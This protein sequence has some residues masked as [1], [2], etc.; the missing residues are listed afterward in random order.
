ML[1]TRCLSR[2]FFPHLQ[3]KSDLESDG[4]AHAI[5]IYDLNRINRS[6]VIRSTQA[7]RSSVRSGNGE[8]PHRP[9][10][11]RRMHALTGRPPQKAR[12]QAESTRFRFVFSYLSLHCSMCACFTMANRF[13]ATVGRCGAPLGAPSPPPPPPPQKKQ[14]QKL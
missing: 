3:S 2:T 4:Q 13:V 9:G 1:P 12:R 6:I 14:K 11:D 10:V 5:A 7:S 8:L